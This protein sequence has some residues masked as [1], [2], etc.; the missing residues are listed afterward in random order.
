MSESSLK[1]PEQAGDDGSPR[2][3]FK[4][5]FARLRRNR[6]ALA[7]MIIMPIIALA[8]VVGPWLLPFDPT[9]SDFDSISVAPLTGGHLF[10]TDNLGRDLL[11]RILVGGRTSLTIAVLA[12]LSAVVVGVCYG[13]VAGYF[14]GLVDTLMMRFVD[15][16][17]G[18]PFLFFVIMLTMVIGRG[19][20][21]IFIAIAALLWLTVAVIT[22]GLTLSLK[23]KEFIEA[24]RAGGMRPLGIVRRHIVPNTVGPVIVY[25]SLL[26]PGVILSESFLSYLGLGVQEPQ[27]SWGVLISDGAEAMDTAPWQLIFPGLFLGVTLFSLNFIAD[28]LR[29]AFDPKDR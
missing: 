17:Y 22:R 6:M 16:L 26:V 2:S 23:Q 5:G 28:G 24:A 20:A 4:D 10:G 29:D 14:G 1:L 3:R 7:G 9:L 11:V 15:V 12:T 18:L 13:A 27:T 19:L 8:C 21:A 25:A